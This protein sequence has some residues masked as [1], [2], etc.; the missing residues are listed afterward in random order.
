[1]SQIEQTLEEILITQRKMLNDL[2]QQKQSIQNIE[3]RLDHLE[4]KTLEV[5]KEPRIPQ[6]L[7]RVLRGIA[8]EENPLSAVDASKKVG[9][10]RNLTSGYLNKLADLGYAVKEPNLE[11]HGA[12]YLFKV[13]YLALPENIKQ[14]LEKYKR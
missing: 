12:R 14:I 5:S 10:S 1:M 13:N 4:S 11:G 6:S 9:L 2:E 7:I 3:Q 8:N